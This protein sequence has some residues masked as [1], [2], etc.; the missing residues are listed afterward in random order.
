MH[1]ILWW[2]FASIC[3]W[4]MYV[5]D[6]THVTYEFQVFQPTGKSKVSLRIF[7][8]NLTQYARLICSHETVITL[9]N[10][11]R[12]GVPK[13]HITTKSAVAEGHVCMVPGGGVGLF[14]LRISVAN[15]QKTVYVFIRCRNRRTAHITGK[16]VLNWYI[17]KNQCTLYKI[18]IK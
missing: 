12:L 15:V 7:K 9:Y 10:G 3:T 5:F 11:Y 4:K 18:F 13:S 1:I 16:L 8:I 14:L 6:E 17:F 2:I